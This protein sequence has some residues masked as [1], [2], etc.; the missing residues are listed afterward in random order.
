M[1]L[2]AASQAPCTIRGAKFGLLLGS[3]CR[4]AIRFSGRKV[5]VS[6]GTSGIGAA[7]AAGFA[8]AGAEVVAAGLPGQNR[9]TR[10][11]R[12]APPRC[13]GHRGGGDLARALG[14]L[15][16]LVNAAGSPPG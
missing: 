13:A 4:D 2:V 8:G 10:A 7:L 12:G 11:V 1:L 15:D 6:G 14:R 16:I 3:L 9:L 5:L